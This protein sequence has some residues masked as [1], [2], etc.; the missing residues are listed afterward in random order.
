MDGR[1]LVYI[2]V[3]VAF[4]VG[5]QSLENRM[6]KQANQH[7]RS[8]EQIT[9]SMWS[10]SKTGFKSGERFRLWKIHRRFF[11]DSTLRF[12]CAMM[13]VLTLIRMF[14]GPKLLYP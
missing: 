11:P 1:L 10:W 14:S 9:R 2:A 4:A 13:F 5:Q 6:M 8:D 7:L 12:F 3:V